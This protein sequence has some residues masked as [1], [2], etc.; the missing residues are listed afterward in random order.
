MHRAVPHIGLFIRTKGRA[1]D[2]HG[3]AE[4]CGHGHDGVSGE[5]DHGDLAGRKV[6]VA[7]SGRGGNFVR[8]TEPNPAVGTW[9]TVYPYNDRNTPLTVTMVRPSGTQVCS[10]TY[11]NAGQ[12]LTATIIE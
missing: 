11:S 1:D 4:Q 2:K 8:V 9:D 10:F 5:Q 7:G 6:E 3:V 12:T